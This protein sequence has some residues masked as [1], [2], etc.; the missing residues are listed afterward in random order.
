MRTSCQRNSSRRCRHMRF[1]SSALR[2]PQYNKDA[3]S[4]HMCVHVH[5][6][7]PD[8]IQP[9]NS[10]FLQEPDQERLV[11]YELRGG[12][13]V[14]FQPFRSPILRQPFCALMMMPP[15]CGDSLSDLKPHAR[16][17]SSPSSRRRWP[18]RMLHRP[19]RSSR[20]GTHHIPPPRTH[21]GCVL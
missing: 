13:E 2:W 7:C 10:R 4:M 18:T 6:A 1:L 20:C 19:R 14:R 15:P 9:L 16:C 3:H 21:F 17:G 8:C 12:E 11:R 5:V